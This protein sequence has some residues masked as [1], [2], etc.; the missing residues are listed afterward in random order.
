MKDYKTSATLMELITRPTIDN[1]EKIPSEIAG[2]L[3]LPVNAGY[4]FTTTRRF[5]WPTLRVHQLPPHKQLL[6]VFKSY[7][8][9]TSCK[10]EVSERAMNYYLKVSHGSRCSSVFFLPLQKLWA[11]KRRQQRSA[12][13]KRRKKILAPSSRW[14]LVS[15]RQSSKSPPTGSCLKSA[16]KDQ[17]SCMNFRL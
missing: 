13:I 12:Q 10:L 8:F 5:T 3:R 4:F 9:T 15:P 11:A 14:N 6:N 1:L 2:L 16:G 7:T 17:T